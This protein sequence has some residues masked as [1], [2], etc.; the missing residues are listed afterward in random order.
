[1]YVV[2]RFEGEFAVLTSKDDKSSL[3][4]ARGELPE[5]AK[6]GATVCRDALGAWTIDEADTQERL[7][8]VRQ[9]MREVF[10][11]SKIS[12]PQRPTDEP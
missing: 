5:G 4:V 11:R 3:D 7:Q 12:K 1:M 6:P 9:L 10:S 8:R 2:D